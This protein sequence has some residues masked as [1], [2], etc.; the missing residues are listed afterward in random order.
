L[1]PPRNLFPPFL[2]FKH[3]RVR[4]A[5]VAFS[6]SICFWGWSPAGFCVLFSILFRRVQTLFFGWRIVF[7]QRQPMAMFT[8][9]FLWFSHFYF[10]GLFDALVIG[11]YGVFLRRCYPRRPRRSILDLW[12]FPIDGPDFDPCLVPCTWPNAVFHSWL[13]CGA[14]CSSL[15]DFCL[16]KVDL[17]VFFPASHLTFKE[18]GPALCGVPAVQSSPTLFFLGH[19]LGPSLFRSL[20]PLV[21]FP[22]ARMFSR[23]FSA[24]GGN[25]SIQYS[26]R[27][28]LF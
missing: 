12:L 6:R 17:V 1:C 21:E 2:S 28:Y 8:P 4:G 10:V 23:Q 18:D 7:K 3:R 20:P 9:P 16:N 25:L 26:T 19:S 22:R 15:F 13:A 24:P 11:W 14:M 27:S 5:R